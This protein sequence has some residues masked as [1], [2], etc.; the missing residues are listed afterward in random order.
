MNQRDMTMYKFLF[1]AI[2]IS[3]LFSSNFV[4]ADQ[5]QFKHKLITLTLPNGWSVNQNLATNKELI[6]GL[7]SQNIAGASILIYSYRGI[8]INYRNVRIR[9]LKQL[10]QIYPKGQNHLKKPKTIKTKAGFNPKYELWQG[11]LDAGSVTVALQSPMAAMKAKNSYILM[12]GYTP[13]V[14]GA[15]MEEDFLKILKSAE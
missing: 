15:K 7:Q 3:I 14:S 4:L 11:F 8:T 6:G 12:I 13:D 10:A 2:I 1:A 9:G 5:A